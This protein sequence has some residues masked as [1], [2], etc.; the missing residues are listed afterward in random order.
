[1]TPPP[2]CVLDFGLCRQCR[3][4][5]LWALWWQ[6]TLV[7]FCFSVTWTQAFLNPTLHTSSGQLL[8]VPVNNSQL[9]SVQVHVAVKRYQVTVFC[10]KSRFPLP[11]E[12]WR[13]SKLYL[14]NNKLQSTEGLA[15]TLAIA[16][17][18]SLSLSDFCCTTSS[19]I[20][21]YVWVSAWRWTPLLGI[22]GICL[23]GSVTVCCMTKA[24]PPH[25]L[26]GSLYASLSMQTVCVF[27]HLLGCVFICVLPLLMF[28]SPD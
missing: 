16:F 19:R 27:S 14:P 13:I 10:W 12:R 3:R 21:L 15:F 7:I 25:T 24:Y 2:P 8:Y 11:D 23:I 1:M 6:M 18:I 5:S 9:M 22:W 28:K 26:C 4:V 20:S 17:K